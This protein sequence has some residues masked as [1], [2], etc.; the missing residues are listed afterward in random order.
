M[1]MFLSFF[2]LI[3]SLTFILIYA[4]AFTPWGNSIVSGL[5]ENKINEKKVIDFKFE[6]FV[7]TINNIN[8]QVN[9]DSNSKISI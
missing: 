5:V 7:L 1:K 8:I 9:I 4:L 2:V 3:I 6:K